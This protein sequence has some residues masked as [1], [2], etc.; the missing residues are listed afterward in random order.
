MAELCTP[1]AD[2]S[3]ARSSAAPEFAAWSEPPAESD[4]SPAPQ[5]AARQMPLPGAAQPRSPEE[6]VQAAAAQKLAALLARPE[7]QVF[8]RTEAL[9]PQA[10]QVRA[11]LQ[12]QRASPQVRGVAL[13]SPQAEPLPAWQLRWVVPPDVP[14]APRP[15]LSSA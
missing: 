3:A 14:E 12:V 8:P 2:R 15:L 5:P 9:R 6:P 11:E 7:Q 4:A 10:A 1:G 13:V